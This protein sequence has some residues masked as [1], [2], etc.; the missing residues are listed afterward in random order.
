MQ[1]TGRERSPASDQAAA[2][3]RSLTLRTA[4]PVVLGNAL[5]FYDFTLYAYFAA[6]IGRQF[7]PADRP[8]AS[9]LLALAGYSVGFVAR[10]VGAVL[11]GR[12][13]D[14][15]GRRRGMLITILL[16]GLGT[17]IIASCPPYASIGLAAPLLVVL[18][19]VLQG[20]SAGAEVGVSSVW[21]MEMARSRERCHWVSWQLASQGAAALASAS[22]ATVLHL[23]LSQ[24]AIESW[25]W[26]VAFALGLLIVP[27]LFYIRRHLPETRSPT[28]RAVRA[29]GLLRSHRAALLYGIV[30]VAGGAIFIQINTHYLPIHLAE[31]LGLPRRSSFLVSCAVGAS[32]LLI[33]P[34]CGRL[35]DRLQRR[36]PVQCLSLCV[37]LVG[38]VPAFAAINAGLSL[39]L[40]VLLITALVTVSMASAGAAFVMLMEAFP[41]GLRATGLSI[42]YGV[43]VTIFGGTAMLVMAGLVELTGNPLA[44][45]WYAALGCAFSLVAL[46]RF[47]EAASGPC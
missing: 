5:E 27:M 25:G 10:P 13:A 26:R 29:T 37:S 22:V 20:F 14:Q 21:L 3:T 2:S 40:S 41:P 28:R 36:K 45:A 16:M 19:R 11:I 47:P 44:P 33:T 6:I 17:A 31:T 42:T 34:L 8:G 7:F 15:Y 43:A 23:T 30:L 24:Q 39:W 35:C 12:L 38:I 4:L 32:M 9:L 1:E 46:R 18:G